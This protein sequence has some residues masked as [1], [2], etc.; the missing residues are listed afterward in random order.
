V[1]AKVGGKQPRRLK[2]KLSIKKVTSSVVGE[3]S[4]NKTTIDEV[5]AGV[6]SE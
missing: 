6:L 3:T 2:V 5:A 4:S 1:E